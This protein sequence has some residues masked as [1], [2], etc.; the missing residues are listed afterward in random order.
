L[1]ATSAALAKQK[2]GRITSTD[3]MCTKSSRVEPTLRPLLAI[4]SPRV[5]QKLAVSLNS[6]VEESF[7][8]RKAGAR[9]SVATAPIVSGSGADLNILNQVFGFGRL[10]MKNW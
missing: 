4:R 9:K 10:W 7:L 6:L 5:M 3:T 2:Y 1:K 8:S